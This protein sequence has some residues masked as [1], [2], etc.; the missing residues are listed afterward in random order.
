MTGKNSNQENKFVIQ[1]TPTYRIRIDRLNTTLLKR[2]TKADV[3]DEIDDEEVDNGYIPL[4]Y[5]GSKHIEHMVR[6]LVIDHITSIGSR[7]HLKLQE[8]I[9]LFDSYVNKLTKQISKHTS[10]GDSLTKTVEEQSNKII[11]LEKTI[12]IM[13]GQ[14][15]KLKKSK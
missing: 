8:Y 6:G 5:Y 9:D 1:L 12:R 3:L 2:K 13:K 7:N 10:V 11:E 15:T 14:I 4:G